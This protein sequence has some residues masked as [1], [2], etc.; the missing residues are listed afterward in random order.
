MIIPDLYTYIHKDTHIERHT[1][2]LEY[3]ILSKLICS[4]E[5]KICVNTEVHMYNY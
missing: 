2:I 1:D 3:E 4:T 5:S